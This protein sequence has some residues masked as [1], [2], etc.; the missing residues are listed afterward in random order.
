VGDPALLAMTSR[1]AMKLIEAGGSDW[2][3]WVPKQAQQ[4]VRRMQADS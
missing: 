2:Q 1:K 4:M 3:H